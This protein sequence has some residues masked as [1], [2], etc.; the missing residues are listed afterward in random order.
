MKLM[1]D[2]EVTAQMKGIYEYIIYSD[3]KHLQL[4]DMKEYAFKDMHTDH[5][6]PWNRGGKTV[7]EN[8]QILCSRYNESKK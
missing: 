2:D 5:I 8:C 7:K 1:S 4:C 3:G 6:Q